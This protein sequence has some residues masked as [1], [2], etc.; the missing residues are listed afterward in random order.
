M[1]SAA[2][3]RKDRRAQMAKAARIYGIKGQE[4][5][6]LH[7]AY[8]AL[9]RG[10]IAEA[11]R[12]SHPI[13]QSHP[14][15]HHAWIVMGGAALGQREGKTAQ[16]FFTLAGQIRPKDPVV[17]AGLAKSHVLQ[18]Q[19]EEAV[20]FAAQALNAGSDDLGLA[21][22]YLDFMSRLGRRLVAA[23]L[24]APVA[25]RLKNADLCFR[26]ADMLVEAEENGK[27]APWYEQAWKLDPA[28]EKHKTG[29]LRALVIQCRFDEAEKLAL[30]LMDKV[31]DRDSVV[32][33]YLLLLRSSRRYDEAEKLA[34]ENDFQTPEGYALS[35][36]V[37]A[38]IHQDRAEWDEAD[39]A[40]LEAIHVTGDGGN[41]NKAY[42]VFLFRSGDYAK[43]AKYFERR[44][45]DQQRARLPAANAAPENL[46]GLNRVTLMAEQGVGD[47]LALLSLLPL[48]PIAK[49][50][51][52]RFVSEAR[53]KPLLEDNTLNLE[54][55]DMAEF[56]TS[57]QEL[58][59]SELVYV[60]DLTRYL[61]GAGKSDWTGSFLRPDT[62]RVQMLREK[63]AEM[64]N[65]APVIGV[66]WKSV[67]L[68][69]LLRS[70]DL[71]ELVDAL[72]ENALLVNL[73]Y[74]DTKDD[75]KA[76]LARRPDLRIISDDTVDQM[77]DLA[78]FA[79]QIAALDHVATI[80]NT[81]AHMAG[82]IG[83]PSTHVLIPTGAE[84]MWYWGDQPGAD[85]WY[86]TLNLHRQEISGNWSVPL[87]VL[88][89]ELAA[90]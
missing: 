40:Y 49:D 83:H 21:G 64:A 22:I 37:M 52:V 27:A 47:Q 86:G 44:L 13:T 71:A 54:H 6:D 20:L 70:I 24:L 81:T 57:A 23:E 63:Y 74:G 53:F 68:I 12:L 15:N 78:G 45:S 46:S 89:S 76:A 3:S 75:I 58:N 77:Q 61:D 4:S 19:V 43:G 34:E 18:A 9:A 56:T 51:P 41:I 72:P 7:N 38:N 28:P 87:A 55:V 33:L 10:E 80:D 59:P 17:L 60:G 65:G 26:L 62:A 85:P 2:P 35:R 29:H 66:A 90:S 82:A 48:A 67:S 5:L 84:C 30:D 16:S 8:N 11:V 79:A 32:G 25:H 42:G 50:V 36:G 73:Q 39:A 14:T 69:G 31:K 1:Q 88:K